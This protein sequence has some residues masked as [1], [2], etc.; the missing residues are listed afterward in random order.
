VADRPPPIETPDRTAERRLALR[1]A[2]ER[3][4][5]NHPDSLSTDEARADDNVTLN[6]LATIVDHGVDFL[7]GGTL[8]SVAMRRVPGEVTEDGKRGKRRDEEVID[9]TEWLEDLWDTKRDTWQRKLGISGGIEGHIAVKIV[10]DMSGPGGKINVKGAHRAIILD[11]EWLTIAHAPGDI[12]DVVGYAIDTAEYAAGSDQPVRMRREQH[13]R[14]ADGKTWTVQWLVTTDREI[15]A[16]MQPTRR[17][18]K[19]EPDPERPDVKV[20]PYPFAAIVDSQNLPRPHRL[21]GR[22]DLTPDILHLQEAINRVASNEAKTIRHFAHPFVWGSAEDP[23]AVTAAIKGAAIGTI[24]I[25]PHGDEQ[26][27]TLQALQMQAEGPAAAAAFRQALEEKLFEVAR[28]PRVSPDSVSGSGALSGVALLLLY[29]PMI[30]KTETKRDTYGDLLS[31][32]DRRLLWIAGWT[33]LRVLLT[34]PEV[35]PKDEAAEISNAREL[36]DLGISLRTLCE[37]LGIDYDQELGR[38]RAEQ[39][40]P[41]GDARGMADRIAELED[42]LARRTGQDPA[43]PAPEDVEAA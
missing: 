34:W 33:D 5:G 38:I 40:D 8:Q 25:L 43:G 4:D 23:S 28:C 42:E 31:E 37:R 29:R 30:A 9:A 35:L 7:F 12:D 6:N 24:P 10:P 20:W 18:V 19:W 15:C 32:L 41:M 21:W 17:V 14:A 16:G 39:D 2:W 22:P 1:T 13:D 26:A 3:Y 11:T 27:T 36:R